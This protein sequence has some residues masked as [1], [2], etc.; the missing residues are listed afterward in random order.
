MRKKFFLER[1]EPDEARA[2]IFETLKDL[3]TPDIIGVEEVLTAE[4]LG[5]VLAESVKAT[6]SVPREYLSAMDGVA[7]K[8][9]FTRS[10]SMSNP[11]LIKEGNFAVINTGNVLPRQFDCVI[12]REDFW[13][14]EQGIIIRTPHQRYQNVRI[15]GEDVLPFDLILE[16]FKVVDGKTM[17]LSIQAGVEKVKVLKRIKTLFIPSGSELRNPG[18]KLLEGEIYETNSFIFAQLLRDLGLDVSVEKIVP[19]DLHELEKV[20]TSAV[21]DF[22]LIFVS[23]GTSAGEYDFTAEILNGKGDLI[24]HGLNLRPGKPFIFGVLDKK[25][26][27][28]LPGYPGAALF[29]Y[30]YVLIP[31]LK[32]FLGIVNGEGLLEASAGRKISASGGEDHLFN[33]VVSKVKEKYWF[34]PLKQGSGP[35][36][37]FIHRSG[38]IIVER[39]V[40]GIEEG[41]QRDVYLKNRREVVDRSVL[42]VGSHDLSTDL[43]K[44]ILWGKHRIPLN[45]VNVGSLGGIMAILRERAHLA[46]VHLMDEETGKY[47]IPFIKKL[48]LK[49]FLLFSFLE[50]EQGFVVRE[51]CEE[52]H[53]FKEIAESGLSFVSRQKGSGTRLLTDFLLKKEGIKPTEIKGYENEVITHV[54]VGYFVKEHLA[55]AGVAVRPVSNLFSLKFIPIG[56]EKYDLLVSKDFAR[57][58]RFKY[59][60]EIINSQEFLK[61]LDE[62]GGYKQVFSEEPIFEG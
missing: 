3:L 9:E 46:G 24:I 36:S 28:G 32:D 48:G 11:V 27:F 54:E 29:S 2:L 59:V 34:Y 37:P 50:R 47:N 12:R 5:R 30:E 51:D 23:G 41:Q 22:Q 42:F 20:L 62:F 56:I 4:S 1:M 49:D 40:E 61:G 26:V 39:G 58:V 7:T 60:I 35:I 6:I 8:S 38:S 10:A 33:V 13:E 52:V 17:A 19:D 57:D 15:P 53:S 14:D 21:K 16:R 31:A 44:E 43:I 45:I 18:E 25:P 55:D